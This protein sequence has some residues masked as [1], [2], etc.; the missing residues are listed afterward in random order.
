MSIEALPCIVCGNTLRNVFPDEVQNQ[1]SDG[2]AFTSSGN[3]GSTVWDQFDGSFIEI[4]VCDSCLVEAGQRGRVM[5]GRDKRP[6]AVEGMLVGWERIERPLVPWTQGLPGYD[7]DT[8]HLAGSDL[9]IPLPASVHLN[10]TVP[11]LL[12]IIAQED[13]QEADAHKDAHAAGIEPPQRWSDCQECVPTVGAT[14]L[15]GA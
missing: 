2:V 3:Y 6:V 8:V 14:G 9:A 7:D 13:Q 1:P 11:E 4:N 5:A 12:D 10:L 15:A